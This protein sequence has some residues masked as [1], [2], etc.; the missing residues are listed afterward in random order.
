MSATQLAAEGGPGGKGGNG[1]P[2][3]PRPTCPGN[4][5]QGNLGRDG[6]FRGPSH[7]F[8]S[9]TNSRIML[10]HSGKRQN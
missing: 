2:S 7:T 3:P 4:C 6:D 5:R 10:S 9:Q 1:P 8:K